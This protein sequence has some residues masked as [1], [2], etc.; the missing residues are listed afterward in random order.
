MVPGFLAL[1]HL[2]LWG[3]F[4]ISDFGGLHLSFSPNHHHLFLIS[5]GAFL[6][7]PNPKPLPIFNSISPSQSL[8]FSC[9]PLLISWPL[10]C[11]SIRAISR[12]NRARNEFIRPRSCSPSPSLAEPAPCS[13]NELQ[14]SPRSRR[15][16]SQ[17]HARRAHEPLAEPPERSPEQPPPEFPFSPELAERPFPFAER[18]HRKLPRLSCLV[19]L[20]P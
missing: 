18:L 5:L 7:Q 3:A 1:S 19:R 12:R 2:C 8:V 15:S 16:P 11:S 6:F 10:S 17:I 9:F 20:L 4:V 14:L 13:P